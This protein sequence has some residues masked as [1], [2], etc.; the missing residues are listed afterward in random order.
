MCSR[1]LRS[2]DSFPPNKMMLRSF[3]WCGL[4]LAHSGASAEAKPDASIGGLTAKFVDVKGVRTRYYEVGQGEPMVMIHG[5]SMAGS[6]T[7]N[8]FSRNIPGLAKRFRV[9][10]L[11]RLASGMTGNPL[12]DKDYNY[13]AEAE[14]VYNFIQT[15]KLGAVHLVGHSAGGGIAFFMAI[16]HPEAVKTLVIIAS[17]PEDPPAI[18]GPTKLDAAL[19]KCPDQKQ[20]EGLECRVTIL[21]WL[22]TT[23]DDEYWEAD[24]F[25]ASQ[26]KT[27]EARAK[28]NAGAGEPQRTKEFP[29]YREKMFARVRDGGALQMPVLL[30]A[31]KNDVLDWGVNDETAKLQR[32][33]ALFDILAAKN[34]KVRMIIQANSG[35]FMYR[36]YP[37]QFNQ[38]IISFI[39]GSSAGGAGM[40]YG[41]SLK[42][43]DQILSS[44][45]RAVNYPVCVY[46]P[47]PPYTKQG[48]KAKLEGSVIVQ[49]LVQE[50]GSV[51]E[52][53]V[54]KSL[55]MDLDQAALET[56]R[57]W[58]FRPALDS[59]GEPVAVSTYV[60]IAFRLPK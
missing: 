3:L 5:G 7:A 31:G 46:C 42:T 56:I 29:A 14:F 50:D 23:F 30:Y 57:K 35:H 37:E 19:P 6:S 13:A 59:R 22:P 36:E 20:Y 54:T 44:A 43:E 24:A 9:F 2:I 45:R 21:A 47:A 28:L 49:V 60:D 39:S 10:A 53:H 52:A 12:D 26:P 25:M 41:G 4:L 55:G 11:D 34:S 48:R 1:N 17:G 18:D 38:D 15:R 51:G 27:K 32:E 16:E 33:L 58:R 40:K 8:V